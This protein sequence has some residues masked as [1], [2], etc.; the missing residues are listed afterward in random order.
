MQANSEKR[1]IIYFIIILVGIIY[2]IKLF[3]LQIIDVDYKLDANNNVLRHIIDYPSRGYIYDRNNKLLVYNEA[4]YDLMVVPRQIKNFDTLDF[5]NTLKIEKSEFIERMTKINEYSIYKASIFEKT[6]SSNMFA[7]LQEKLYKYHGFYVQKRTIRKYPESS[8]GH[9]L[10]YI[11]EVGDRDIEND[12]YYKSGDYIGISGIEKSYENELRGIRGI[13]IIMVD[14]HNR[15]KG[16][17]KDGLY[18]SI[19]VP[20]KDINITIDNELQK[21]GELLMQNKIGS[22][23]AIEPSTGEILA[24]VSSPTYDPNLLV[25]RVRTQNYKMLSSD[26]IK[27]LFNR[28]LMAKYPPGSTF[29]LINAL[30]GLQEGVLFEDTKCSCKGG[31]R[32][33]RLTVGCHPHPSPLDL[34][35]SIQISCNAYYCNV[36]R[37]IIDNDYYDGAREGYINWRKHISSFNFGRKLY[38]DLNNES[39]GFIPPPEYYD[40]YYGKNRWKSLTIISLAIGQGEI[41]VT[42]LQLA[43]AVSIIANRGYYFTPH[44]IKRINNKNIKIKKFKTKKYTT[45]DRKYFYPVI[46][47]MELVVQGEAWSTGRIA[48]IDSIIICGKTGTAENPHGE[49]HSIFVAFAPKDNPKIAISVIVENAGFGSTFAAPIAS[50]M[51]EK[52]LNDSI[53]RKELEEKIITSNL[54]CPSCA[55]KKK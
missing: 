52:Y 8:A 3:I 46:E 18:D 26:S 29:K 21:Y 14:V 34:R 41:G 37:N 39:E 4:A 16:S 10:G 42:P 40:R 55:N 38:S 32:S 54:I 27:P 35:Q 2:L 23:V 25:G 50:L 7:V 11:G 24:I 45:I 31:Y 15:E 53:S 12:G 22:I 9:L 1:N 5:C 13:S 28:A 51:I 19:S 48:R 47:G 20:G 43:N 30:I 36:F 17:Y 44:I 6:I 49:D 33:G